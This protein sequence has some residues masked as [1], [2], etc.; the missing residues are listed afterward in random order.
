MGA[1]SGG[2]GGEREGKTREG[3]EGEREGGQE[4][5]RVEERSSTRRRRRWGAVS[6]RWE[7]IL[8]C[9]F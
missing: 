8:I 5:R 3:D 6:F 4:R 9:K 7:L 2:R 1:L